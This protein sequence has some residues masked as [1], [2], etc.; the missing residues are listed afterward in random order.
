MYVMILISKLNR[1]I[2]PSNHVTVVNTVNN[3]NA[4]K[5]QFRNTYPSKETNIIAIGGK[6]TKLSLSM[7]PTYSVLRTETPE[8]VQVG[9]VS[10]ASFLIFSYTA[11]RS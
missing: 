7:Y 5:T 6:K 2:I 8:N 9:E 3:G 4:T 1:P 10:R 11:L